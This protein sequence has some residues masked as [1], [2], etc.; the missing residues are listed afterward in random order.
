[1]NRKPV[2]QPEPWD[3]AVVGAGPAGSVCACSALAASDGLR[4]A[5]I[6]R[7]T[8]PRDKSC[9]DAIRDDAVSTLGEL[10]L[11]AIFESRPS[12]RCLRPTFPL[13]FQYLKKLVDWD[14]YAY[15]IV[16]RKPFDNALY[17]AAV[18]RGAQDFTGYRLT[19]AAL[20]ESVG[21]WT[22]TLKA[23]SGQEVAICSKVLVGADGASS[24]VR[25]IVGL[26]LNKDA[27]LAVGLRA[28]AHAEG[29]DMGALR[30][31]YLESLIPGYGWTFPL[32]DGKVNIGI[33][34]DVRDYRRIGKNLRA[35]LDDYA[36]YLAGQGVRLRDLSDVKTH[37]LPMGSRVLPL[38]PQRH[39]ALIGDAAAMID[40]FTGEGI[41][42][43][44]WA[45]RVA[46]RAAAE[47]I[48]EGDPQAGLERYAKA[49]AESFGS[50]MGDSQR[51]RVMLRFQRM[52]L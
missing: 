47:S 8:F 11:D 22:L 16:E 40:P 5:L 34:L 1:M 20:E 19:D 38:V 17:E 44:I 6:D 23:R 30:I 28:Y 42:F 50:T 26:D 48:C 25:R 32:K 10:G 52:F 39:V 7:E 4:V 35:H 31:D 24:Q 29:L 14:Q 9:G 12:I 18:Q 37:P 33:F 13:K 45:G 21:L 3:I 46:G 27:H 51:L 49:C 2:V 36:Q 43:G 15:R 41:H